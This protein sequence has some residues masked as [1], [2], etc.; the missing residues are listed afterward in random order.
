MTIIIIIKH[1][2]DD[3]MLL[4]HIS[5]HQNSRNLRL[6]DYYIMLRWFFGKSAS[7]DVSNEDVVA[8]KKSKKRSK[9]KDEEGTSSSSSDCES[10]SSESSDICER[11]SKK[12]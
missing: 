4:L 5:Y 3:H 12:K 8:K 10:S 6:S 9:D 11:K 7:D 2:T 1:V